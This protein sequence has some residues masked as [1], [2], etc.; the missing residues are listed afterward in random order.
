MQEY[1]KL[2]EK[3]L[4]RFSLIKT[5]Y[6]HQRYNHWRGASV[7]ITSDSH[8]L[9]RTTFDLSG[10]NRTVLFRSAEGHADYVIRMDNPR[11]V[12]WL[13]H[14]LRNAGTCNNKHH[15]YACIAEAA[16]YY[17]ARHACETDSEIQQLLLHCLGAAEKLITENKQFVQSELDEINSVFEEYSTH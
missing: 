16:K 10:G 6:N 5:L 8:Y 1:Q 11:P 12:I 2:N 15:F 14:Q 3:I 17:L 7:I 9:E 4:N 13:F